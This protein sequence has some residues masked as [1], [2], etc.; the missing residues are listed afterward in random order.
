MK[1]KQIKIED[2]D[3][4]F[5]MQIQDSQIKVRKLIFVNVKINVCTSDN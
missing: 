4:R 3:Q 5:K 1:E 2:L